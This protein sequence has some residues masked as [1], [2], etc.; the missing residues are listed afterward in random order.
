MKNI[1]IASREIVGQTQPP[2]STNIQLMVDDLRH[3]WQAVLAE[4]T[5]RRDK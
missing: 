4:L 2:E 3:R 1:G 5:T